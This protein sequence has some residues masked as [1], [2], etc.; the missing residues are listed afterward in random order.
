[1]DEPVLL[2]NPIDD[3]SE[4][5]ELRSDRWTASPLTGRNS[6]RQDL[7]HRL[8]VH[9]EPMRRLPSAQSLMMTR[10]PDPSV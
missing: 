8:A 4:W 10:K 9:A 6:V 1:M 3:A 2:D 5:I 7:R